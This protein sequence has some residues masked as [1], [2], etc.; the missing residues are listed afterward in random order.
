MTTIKFVK[1]L[2]KERKKKNEKENVIFLTFHPSTLSRAKTNKTN[3]VIVIVFS[4]TL[5]I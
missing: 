1:N 3:R 4:T 5:A 2:K